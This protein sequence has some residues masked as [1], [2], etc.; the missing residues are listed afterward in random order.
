MVEGEGEQELIE[1]RVEVNI[2]DGEG[3]HGGG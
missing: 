3:E 2:V 1:W